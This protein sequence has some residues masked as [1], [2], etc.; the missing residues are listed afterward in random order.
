MSREVEVAV[1]QPSKGS[2]GSDSRVP[3]S[4]SNK[5][6]SHGV[7]PRTCSSVEGV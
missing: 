5:S 2:V 7:P 1:S 6:G 4:S 3:L